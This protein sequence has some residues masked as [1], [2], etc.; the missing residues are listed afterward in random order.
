MGAPSS[1]TAVT[2]RRT[3]LCGLGACTLLGAR[4]AFAGLLPDRP[5]I[6]S[7]ANLHTGEKVKIAYASGA[8]YI[9]EGLSKIAHVLRDHRNG[10][11]HEIDPKLLDTLFLLRD[12]LEVQKDF[13]VISGY[14]SPESNA[15]LHAA[16]DGVAEHSLHMEGQAIDI[17][18]PGVELAHLR[19]AAKSLKAGG[20]GYYPKSEFVHV[21]VGRVRYW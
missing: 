12:R 8:E 14:R 1:S 11:T 3:L 20:V 13:E 6:L 10:T 16:S 5:R 9:A 2:S 15:K 18:V 21:D 4:P 19:D 7:F 17:R